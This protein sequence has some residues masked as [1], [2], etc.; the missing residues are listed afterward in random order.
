M[1][2]FSTVVKSFQRGAIKHSPEILT[3]IGI[4]CVFTAAILTGKAT[5]KAVEIVEEKRREANE[6]LNKKGIVKVVWKK[7]I[8]AAGFFAVGV[9]CIIGARSITARRTA[10][11]TAAYH[12][13]ETA[14]QEYKDA[15]KETVGEEKEKKVRETVAKNQVKEHP[16]TSEI[17]IAKDKVLCYEPVSGRYFSSDINEIQRAV[18]T[19]NFRLRNEMWV[20]LNEFYY[21]LGLEPTIPGNELGWNIDNGMFEVSFTTTL[22]KDDRPCLVICYDKIPSYD[23]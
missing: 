13:S 11:M 22:S 8:P 18:N 21:E 7:Y 16:V 5:I 17:I 2:K 14:F 19:C 6:P 20:S 1:S 15:V 4:G 3:G 9:G 10:A 12:I 23:M